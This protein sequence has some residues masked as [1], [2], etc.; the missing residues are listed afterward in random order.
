MDKIPNDVMKDMPKDI[1]ELYPSMM[2]MMKNIGFDPMSFIKETINEQENK[3]KKKKKNKDDLLNQYDDVKEPTDFSKKSIISDKDRELRQN[4][5]IYDGFNEKVHK[6]LNMISQKFPESHFQEKYKNFHR[7]ID[8]A[9]SS[10]KTKPMELWNKFI[11]DNP[12]RS[13][14]LSKY[15]PEHVKFFLDEADSFPGWLKAL[16]IHIYHNRFT[17]KD[18]QTL[19]IEFGDLLNLSTATEAVAPKFMN[20]IQKTAYDIESKYA[21]DMSNMKEAKKIVATEI[22]KNPEIREGIKGMM[23]EMMNTMQKNENN[24][25]IPVPDSYMK[26][27]EKFNN[28]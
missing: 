11:N 7:I 5:L 10:D 19:W 9:I 1:N 28:S 3:K 13:T 15:S 17:P 26:L 21:F 6:L 27:I 25:Q 8:T 2:D 4:H 18:F 12:K 24:S 16:D 14:W 20:V 22:F 23:M